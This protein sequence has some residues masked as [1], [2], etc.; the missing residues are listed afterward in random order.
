MEMIGGN[1]VIF[2]KSSDSNIT[3]MKMIVPTKDGKSVYQIVI[4]VSIL[5]KAELEKVMLS[6][7]K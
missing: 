6:I 3:G 4:T 2:G 7:L 1:Q 5:N